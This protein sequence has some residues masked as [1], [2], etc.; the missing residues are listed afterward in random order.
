MQK[1]NRKFGIRMKSVFDNSNI[2]NVNVH[3]TIIPVVPPWTLHQ[4]RVNLDI[5]NLST[6]DTSPIVFIQNYIEIKDEHSYCTPI[7]TDE[8]KHNDRVAQQS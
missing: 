1:C 3:D 5:S 8:S 7:Y 2:L 4:P 6:N